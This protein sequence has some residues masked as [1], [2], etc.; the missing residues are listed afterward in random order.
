MGLPTPPWLLKLDKVAVWRPDDVKCLFPEYFPELPPA[1]DIWDFISSA[2]RAIVRKHNSAARLARRLVQCG[3]LAALS[4]YKFHSWADLE[5]N[6]S[7]RALTRDELS[8][9]R[10]RQQG[11][12]FSHLGERFDAGLTVLYRLRG[13]S[14]LL[15][16][17]EKVLRDENYVAYLDTITRTMFKDIGAWVKQRGDIIPDWKDGINLELLGDYVPA[18]NLQD[19]ASDV[20]EWVGPWDGP[21]PGST[22]PGWRAYFFS[23]AREFARGCDAAVPA[24]TF[25]QFIDSGDWA[26][27]GAVEIDF[28]LAVSYDDGTAVPLRKTKT[29]VSISLTGEEIWT[30]LGQPGEQKVRAIVKRE[31]G[32]ARAVAITDFP[33]YLRMAWLG[34]DV[35]R[36]LR[37]NPNSTLFMNSEA[38]SEFWA[39]LLKEAEYSHL[40]KCPVD[41][42]NFDHNVSFE[43][44]GII[45]DTINIMLTTDEQRSVLREV[46]RALVEQ[47]GVVAVGSEKI[48]VCKGVLSGW[49]WTALIDTWVNFSQVWAFSYWLYTE[50]ICTTPLSRDNFTVQGDDIRVIFPNRQAAVAFCEAYKAAG[51]GV[52][53]SKTWISDSRDEFLRQVAQSGRVQGY[54]SRAV[55]ALLW[56]NPI[57]DAP[58]DVLAALAS[59]ATRW[60]T[61]VLRGGNLE[62]VVSLVWCELGNI[63][64][65]A[66]TQK[67]LA[68][69]LAAPAS[70]GGVGAPFLVDAAHVG[71]R[72]YWVPGH[73]TPYPMTGNLSGA[74]GFEAAVASSPHRDCLV[75]RRI[76]LDLVR[77]QMTPFNSRALYPRRRLPPPP[78]YRI[79]IPLR[80][81]LAKLGGA[82]GPLFPKFLP[83]NDEPSWIRAATIDFLAQERRY[84][85]LDLLL[86]P[87]FRRI[88][89]HMR[90]NQGKRVWLDWFKGTLDLPIPRVT[91][92]GPAYLSGVFGRV[93]KHLLVSAL[94]GGW[95]L[96]GAGWE[97]LAASFQDHVRSKLTRIPGVLA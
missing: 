92:H 85:E 84:D 23:G 36:V 35:E 95:R 3:S 62:A 1:D 16:C 13:G 30:L 86:V 93:K 26:R 28:P 15:Q 76:A 52:N 88:S 27:P 57:N 60:C 51:Y 22:L 75:F 29:G 79:P 2:F 96:R 48:P 83:R 45:L 44:I 18:P 91:S 58:I 59:L 67:R 38:L 41:Q 34:E 71:A 55:P 12:R 61:I 56:R 82:V 21:Q 73:T 42:S 97:V 40:I 81:N 4:R 19:F 11:G 14:R 65:G 46:R 6:L 47:P 9:R 68:S 37:S 20:A 53:P 8:R 77:K 87:P 5:A 78:E 49:R 39:K 32:K 43:D 33:T 70:I 69:F 89:A 54:L 10:L 94:Y 80:T 17:L 72:G 24:R 64:F 90:R 74:A 63:A 31:L 7:A 25:R 50:G 66:W